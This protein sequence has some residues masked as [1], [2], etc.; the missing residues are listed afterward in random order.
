MCPTTGSDAVLGEQGRPTRIHRLARV[1]RVP[2]LDCAP[3]ASPR[4]TCAAHLLLQHITSPPATTYSD[5]V[6]PCK[7]QRQQPYCLLYRVRDAWHPSIGSIESAGLRPSHPPGAL[8]SRPGWV[9]PS[10]QT[11]ER[12][13]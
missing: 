3:S 8:G 12:R 9:A 4:G 2:R 6:C 13:L 10:T 1:T 11:R 7:R 5:K